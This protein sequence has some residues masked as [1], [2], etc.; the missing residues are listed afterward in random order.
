MTKIREKT[1]ILLYV[2]VFAFIALIVIEWGANW[3]DLSRMKRGIIGKI[4]GEDV[5]YA[6]FQTTYFNQVQQAQ[7]QRGGEALSESEM[8]SISDQVWNQLVEERILRDFIRKN[9]IIASDSEIAFSLKNNPPDFLRQSPAFQTDGKFDASKYIQALNNPQFG[10]QW[11][12]IEGILRQ[13]LPYSKIQPLVQSAIRVTESEI[14]MEYM[15]RNL[16]LNAKVLY[17]SPA[18]IPVNDIQVSEDELR[19]YYKKHAD[20]FKEPAKARLAFVNFSE[21]PT[22]EDSAEVFNRL[23]EIKKQLKEGKDFD[24]LAR[25]YSAD[26]G[27]AEQG[28]SLGWFTKG[29]MV[30]EFEDAC[31]NANIGEI[32]GPVQTQFGYHIIRVDSLKKA[33]VKKTKKDKKEAKTEEPKDSIFARHILI[34]MEASSKTVE[35][36]RESANAF[37]E[38]AREEGFAAAFERFGSR[39]NLR[40]DTTIEFTDN[41]RGLVAG[42]SEPLRS[43]VRYAFNEHR[44]S[45]MRPIRT[46]I[47]FTIFTSVAYQKAG[48]RPFEAVMEKVK[49]FVIEEKRRQAVLAKGREIRAK[50]N[51]IEDIQKIDSLRI[52][53]ELTAFNMNG[54]VPGVGRDVKLNQFLFQQPTSQLLDAFLGTR[55]AYIVYIQDREEFVEAKYQAARAGI[56]QQLQNIKMQRAY[57]DW[58]DMAKKKMKVEDFRADFNL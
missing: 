37:Y 41:D 8:E 23:A 14:R 4:G 42:F 27:S 54:T 15:R 9:G 28:G 55:G 12:E 18:E 26:R 39:Y 21:Q 6:D 46:A 3:S 35:L 10:R 2:L 34:R 25:I 44:E 43:V 38:T 17:F 5:R 50:M 29:V 30:K 11:T 36:A 47:G 49:G 22:A 20:D 1:H 19:E 32:V 51:T 13:Q 52:I 24:E 16:K 45:V 58:L 53:R 56:R 33:V 7:Q 40:I 48:V 57:R 31:F